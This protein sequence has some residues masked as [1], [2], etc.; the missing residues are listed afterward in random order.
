MVIGRCAPRGSR[1]VQ[2]A[3][4]LSGV[5]LTALVSIVAGSRLGRMLDDLWQVFPA[6]AGFRGIVYAAVPFALIAATILITRRVR[7]ES[8]RRW[9]P[10]G[11]LLLLVAIR[12]GAILLAPTPLTADND[13]RYLHELAVG[14]LEG[15]NPIVAHRPMGYSTLLGALY[16]A[17]GVH[18]VLAEFLNLGFATLAGWTLF[19]MVARA[20]DRRAAAAALLLYALVPSQILLVT[21]VFTETMYSAVLIAAIALASEAVMTRRMGL[22]VSAGIVLALSQYV[23]PVSQAFLAMFAAAPLLYGIRWSR[24]GVLSLAIAASFLVAMVPIALH[25]ASVHGAL[26]L[27]TSSYGGWSVFVGA[28]QEHDGRFN[29]DDQAILHDTPGNT[30]WERSETLGRAGVDRII[31]DPRAFA[32]L[33]LRKFRVLWDDDTYGQSNAFPGW[34]VTDPLNPALAVASQ[35]VY[36]LLAALATVGL[37]RSRQRPRPAA[38]LLAGVLVTIALA[39]VFVEVQ[40]RYHAYVIPLL[41]ALAGPVL[42]GRRTDREPRTTSTPELATA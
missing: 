10:I 42:A 41:C 36:V 38:L 15:G 23:R 22:A 24:A 34:T 35:G 31:S 7:E 37:W 18:P 4:I 1:A 27:S 17:F 19:M 25:N 11:P 16:A 5:V 20:W 33:V 39:H 3:V 32:E 9:T 28:N 6:T 30:V 8:L 40:P 21:T 12:I 29:G 26:S 2:A 14:V 13:P